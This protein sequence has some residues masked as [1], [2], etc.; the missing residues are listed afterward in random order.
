MRKKLFWSIIPVSLVLIPAFFVF[1]LWPT[2]PGSAL[3]EKAMALS[4]VHSN[5][6]RK[7][8]HVVIVDY[9]LPLFMKRL[10]VVDAESGE[11]VLRAHVSHAWNSGFWVPTKFSNVPGSRISSKGCFRTGESYH[12]R[13]G[14]AMRVDGLEP[15]KNDNAR[16]RALVFHPA[17]GPWSGGCF[18]TFPSVNR[19]IIGLIKGGNFMYV[20]KSPTKPTPGS[21]S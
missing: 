17:S 10:W 21:T 6:V 20:H 19:R 4:K 3:V 8:D 5:S 9:D 2:E 7:K 12:G 11:T 13:F 16:P 18:M 14:L 15:G 1:A